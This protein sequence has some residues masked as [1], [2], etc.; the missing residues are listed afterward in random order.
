MYVKRACSALKL[1][2]PAFRGNP[3]LL[4]ASKAAQEHVGATERLLSPDVGGWPQY[5][6]PLTHTHPRGRVGGLPIDK[7]A[8]NC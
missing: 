5:S 2:G 1:M 7:E 3:R 4:A 6:L 8:Q